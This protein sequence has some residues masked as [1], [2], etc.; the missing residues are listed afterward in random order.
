MVDQIL[1]K[2]GDLSIQESF[3]AALGAVNGAA[4]VGKILGK[5]PQFTRNTT[6]LQVFDAV[7]AELAGQGVYLHLDNHMS[8]ATWCCGTGDGNAW[9]GDTD[10][11]VT[12]WTR[13]WGYMAAHV[14]LHPISFSKK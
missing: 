4:V 10:F 2:G 14:N 3:T 13:G 7:A 11:N 1:D 8:R 9:F 6:R 12:K 5:N